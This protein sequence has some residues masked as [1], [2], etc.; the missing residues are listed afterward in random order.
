MRVF[1]S[2]REL[3][4]AR[5][6]ARSV[7]TIGKFDG[8]HV[9][10]REIVRLMQECAD[11]DQLTSV[12]ITFAEHPAH[13]LATL[14]AAAPAPPFHELTSPRQKLESLQSLG[15]DVLV[16][17]PFNQ[18]LREMSA[19]E[20][21]QNILVKQLRMHTIIAGKDFR[22][23]ARAQG[24][25]ETLRNHSKEFDYRVLCL[26]DVQIAQQHVSSSRIRELVQAGNVED[27]ASLLGAFHR[28][29]A[30]I[31]YGDRRGRELG[32][33]T[34]NLAQDWEGAMPAEGIYAGFAIL[35]PDPDSNAVDVDELQSKKYFAAISVGTNP[36][37]GSGTPIRAEA[38]LLDFSQDI[39]GRE[40]TLEFCKKIR[41]M[42]S[43]ISVD[44]LIAAMNRDVR[45]VRETLLR[46]TD[47]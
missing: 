17:L 30:K 44:E 22:F 2:L 10:H 35:G 36:T 7:V 15:V 40:I 45:N 34:A 29:R 33:P 47:S 19:Q 39:Y 28:V 5:F 11:R 27:A 43:F 13:V 20:F 31:V 38:H 4:E 14:R 16:V 46:L 9:G 3:R 18:E 1:W 37:F 41:D 26:D 32:F 25:V 6:A 21:L 23:G 42:E 8:V 12:V 24:T